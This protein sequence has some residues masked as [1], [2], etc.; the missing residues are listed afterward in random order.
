VSD[1]A[2]IRM[3]D[4]AQG[5]TLFGQ[6]FSFRLSFYIVQI[7]IEFNKICLYR[8]VKMT[9]VSIGVMVREKMVYIYRIIAAG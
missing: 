1:P 9:I 2:A 6:S 4:V 3:M 5:Q 7:S 8:C